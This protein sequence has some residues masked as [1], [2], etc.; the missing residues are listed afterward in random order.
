MGMILR[1]SPWHDKHEVKKGDYGEELVRRILESHGFVVY[2]AVTE[3]AHLIDFIVELD[4]NLIFAVDVKTKEMMIK[5][6]ETGFN[7]SNYEHY[8]DFSTRARMPV[9][10]AFVDPRKKTI[11]GNFLSVLDEPRIQA[12]IKYP[13]T[14]P[15]KHYKTGQLIRYYP[16]CAM[17]PLGTLT[18]I[19]V[20]Y[21]KR[22]STG[23][24]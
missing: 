22:H 2:Q 19:D 21:L 9:L 18:D 15:A 17:L 7:Y 6:A 3:G 12:G 13:K 23:H 4:K 5:Y 1:N 20:A 11:Y 10:I 16:E 8:R 24:Y 14:M